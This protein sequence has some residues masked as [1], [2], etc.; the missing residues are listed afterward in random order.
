LNQFGGSFGGPIVKDRAFFFTNYEGSR[1][2]RA[3]TRTFSL[4]S[5]K[6]RGGDFSGLPVIYDPART[7]P[8]GR[9]LPF[10]GNK[11]PAARL[12]P[13]ALAFLQKVP[14]PTSTGEVQNFL[15]SIFLNPD[16]D[17]STPAGPILH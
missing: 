15:T 13:V 17:Q 5:A 4:P 16:P 9:R 10:E 6:V 7:D 11:I 3:L 1:E 2:R 8:T 14:L 12:N